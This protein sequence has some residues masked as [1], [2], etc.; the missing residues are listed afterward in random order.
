MRKQSLCS[1]FSCKCENMD[2]ITEI[3]GNDV[4]I[5]LVHLQFVNLC[6]STISNVCLLMHIITSHIRVSR[7]FWDSDYMNNTSKCRCWKNPT[8]T[9][10]CVR[11]GFDIKN[12]YQRK[13]TCRQVRHVSMELPTMLN[14]HIHAC[15]RTRILHALH[16]NH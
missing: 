10:Y 7:G 13:S 16:S 5:Y 4:T 15:A 6:F 11:G 1:K 3:N 9:Q 2:L 8:E 12:S 14:I